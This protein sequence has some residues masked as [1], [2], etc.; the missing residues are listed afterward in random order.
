MSTNISNLNV[1]LTCNIS[2]FAASM[3][4]A[5]KP[6]K[7]FGGHVAAIG[8]KVGG[9]AAALGGTA[10][11]TGITGLGIWA[12]KLAADAEQAKV[13]FTTMLGSAEAAKALM[14][15][16][17]SFAAATPFQTTELIDASKKLLAFGVSSDQVIPSLRTLGDIAAGL[18][19]PLGD[20]AEIYG[21]ARVQGRL[22]AEDINQ[23]TGRGIPVIAEFAKQFG[24]TE[25]EVKKLVE[26]GQI[27]FPNLQRALVSLT[28]E[29]GKFSGLME[30]QSQTVS[31]LW[32]TLQ[33]SIT[34]NVTRIGE[35]ITEKL[36]LRG[37]IAGI[38]TMVSSLASVAIPIIENFLTRLAAIGN[39]GKGMGGL[40]LSGTEMLAKGLAGAYD[41]CGLLV[42]GFRY[43][44]SGIFWAMSLA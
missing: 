14:A 28:S 19:I 6:L 42:A 13:S 31:G 24:V 39:T 1:K 43:V 4:A 41:A 20:L 9:F 34:L 37:A 16:I 11:T 38:S 35:I 12:V 29:G 30:A 44:Q 23:L 26:Q 21:K 18:N 40:A 22:M 17:N 5:I 7:E 32:S 3:R 27:G 33:D 36:D 10:L 15:Q 2:S 25:G 8:A